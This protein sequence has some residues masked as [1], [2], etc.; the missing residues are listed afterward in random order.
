M[1]LQNG[2][3]FRARE[4]LQK[5]M[6][7]KLPVKASYQVAKLANTLNLQ[8]KIVD[9]VRNKLITE[10]G[11]K[12]ESG[13]ISIDQTSP[14]LPKFLEEFGELLEQE[15]DLQI[16][17]VKLPESVSATCDSCHHNMNR[18]LEVEPSILMALEKFIIV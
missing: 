9:D 14:N 8:L 13:Q 15:V 17:K 12:S 2:D 3:I 10:Y 6:E 7:V 4:P 11:T 16:E 1:K 18:Q 5:L